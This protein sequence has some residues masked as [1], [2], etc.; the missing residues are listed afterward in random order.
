[1]VL[2][3]ISCR[4][5]S[6]GLDDKKRRW[7]WGCGDSNVG[8]GE[9][10]V[11]PWCLDDIYR[12]WCSL[13]CGANS[14]H[15]AFRTKSGQLLLLGL[16]DMKCLFVYTGPLWQG[17]VYDNRGTWVE[18]TS[19][20]YSGGG[21]LC[22]NKGSMVLRH[23]WWYKRFTIPDAV[24]LKRS[25]VFLVTVCRCPRW[26]GV[27]KALS[28]TITN[29]RYSCMKAWGL[30]L[31]FAEDHFNSTRCVRHTSPLN[32]AEYQRRSE[33]LDERIDFLYYF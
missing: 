1:M 10:L 19:S 3:T 2:I 17:G 23:G 28:I 22:R 8:W 13:L 11:G 32:G 27:H 12:W 6:W 9:L 4:C 31:E 25:T 29:L 33:G 7:C 21:P 26:H 18:I 5:C 15:G 16:A 14:I 24:A 20:P 30:G